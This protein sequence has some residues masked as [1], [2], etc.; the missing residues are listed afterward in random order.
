MMSQLPH[1]LQRANKI[2]Q[3][4]AL[5]AMA[6]MNTQK[7]DACTALLTLDD[8]SPQKLVTMISEL[9]SLTIIQLD[10]FDYISCCQRLGVSDLVCRHSALPLHID[11]HQLTLAISDPSIA[12]IE[13][14]FRFATGLKVKLVLCQI[15]ILMEAIHH[16]YGDKFSG[17][18]FGFK[19]IS[20]QELEQLV[21]TT[22]EESADHE[23]L[24]QDTSPISQYIHQ[25]LL[26][27]VRKRASD[28]H[29][30]PY[31]NW[32]RVRFRC[33]GLLIERQQPPHHLS[34]RLIA[35]LKIL[36]KLDIAERRLPQ[37]GRI[38]LAIASSKAID[39]RV[40]TLPT[41]WGEKVVLR[42]LDNRKTSF[43]LEHLGYS[44]S[45]SEHY[46]R[47]LAKPQG[48]I[49]IT[50][51]TGSGK[52]LSLYS[53]LNIL[54]QSE[55][56]IATAEDP[57]EMHVSGI[58]QVQIQ[59]QIG[60]HFAQALRAFLRQDP[61][62][63][64]VGEIR[65]RETAEIAAKAA[66]TGHLVLSTLHTN[67]AAE[68]ILRLQNLGI[69]PFNIAASLS[70][71]VAQRLVRRLCPHCKRPD[72][73][74]IQEFKAD[75]LGCSSCHQG[76]S[77]RI[78]LFEILTVTPEISEAI[79]ARAPTHHIESLAIEQGMQTLRQSGIEKLTQGVTSQTELQR[80]LL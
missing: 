65:D 50:G 30:E 25:V 19:A 62:V 8:I 69:E 43:D 48:M 23:A 6:A 35:R 45:Q 33:D 39:I 38:T 59:P 15:H 7:A 11:S 55:V 40:S 29:F 34:N 70:L 14:D 31:E 52:T 68:A 28:I 76:Y 26:D 58:N 37:D 46:R 2:T 51:P 24:Y 18:R 73:E 57:V 10:S 72:S 47:A 80:V 36:A 60:F 79:A 4:Q 22:E 21:E 61:D 54:N 78:G 71:I 49:L 56:N 16:L 44:P 5:H 41:I 75:P 3:A 42:L 77:G 13:Q 1:L 32:F 9:F 20:D 27:A 17:E 53:G 66:Q 12:E 74:K 63:V 67:S 64:M